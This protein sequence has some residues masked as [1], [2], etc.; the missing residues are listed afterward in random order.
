MI[1]RVAEYRG[2][3]SPETVARYVEDSFDSLHS[4]AAVREFLTVLVE[5]LCRERLRALAF[6]GGADRGAPGFK[7]HVPFER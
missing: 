3:F 5:R 2:V 6:A 4:H 7:P 1:G